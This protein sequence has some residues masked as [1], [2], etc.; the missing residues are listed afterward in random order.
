MGADKSKSRATPPNKVEKIRHSYRFL[1]ARE[2]AAVPFTVAELATTVGWKPGTIKTYLGKKW[3]QFVHWDGTGSYRAQGLSTYTEDEYTRLMSQ[4]DEVSADPRRPALAPEVEAFV[5]KARE[6]ALLGLH[7]YN[8]PTTVFRTEGFSVLMVIAWTAFFH[9]VFEQRG[10]SYFYFEADRTPKLVD[11]DKKAWE[12]GT[13]IAEFWPAGAQLAVRSNL[14]F[15]IKFRNRVEHRYV[16]AIDAHVAGECQALLLNFDEMMVQH[17]GS[18]YAIRESLAVPLQTSSVRTVGGTEA[19]RKLQ[20]KHFDDMKAFVDTYRKELAPEVYEDPRF[21]FRVFL[22]PK[23]G[24]HAN[25][26]DLAYEFVK[27]DPSRPE[28]MSKL[29]KQITLIK[30]KQVSVANAN[31]LSPKVVAKQVAARIGRTFNLHHHTLAWQKF[32]VRRSGFDASACNTK[33]CVA[34]PRHEDYGYTTAWVDF[35]VTKLSSQADYDALVA[36]LPQV[37]QPARIR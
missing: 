34:D 1:L 33:Y 3:N 35:L 10:T 2:Q 30:E 25:S 8:S 26:S 20:A 5:R 7:I 16:P 36:Y 9:A 23:A 18:Y 22:V 4:R 27:Y 11:G 6:S 24:N 13:C 19:L 37:G 31:L 12:L 14:D 28:E 21:A 32:A 17:F 29:Q 15:F